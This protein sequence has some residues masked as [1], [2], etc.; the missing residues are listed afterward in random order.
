MEITQSSGNS[1]EEMHETVKNTYYTTVPLFF[2]AVRLTKE[3]KHWVYMCVYIYT[4]TNILFLHIVNSKYQDIINSSTEPM[5][6]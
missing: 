6:L 4:Q 1:N 2:L 5:I 3:G